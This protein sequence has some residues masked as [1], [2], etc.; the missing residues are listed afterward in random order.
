MS[1][2]ITLKHVVTLELL[3]T[4]LGACHSTLGRRK[5][6]RLGHVNRVIAMGTATS[7]IRSPETVYSVRM[8]TSGRNC[9]RCKEGFYGNATLKTCQRMCIFYF[10]NTTR[11][12]SITITLIV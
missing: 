5:F 10:S 4:N 6:G 1:D 7:A 3:N 11:L 12:N 2:N 9:E 8:D